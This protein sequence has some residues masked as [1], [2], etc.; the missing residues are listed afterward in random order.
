MNLIP[1]PFSIKWEVGM[2]MNDNMERRNKVIAAWRG[3]VKTQSVAMSV[4]LAWIISNQCP[5]N[6]SH[7]CYYLSQLA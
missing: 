2:I 3:Y 4:A 7:T 6:M 1:W 5:Q